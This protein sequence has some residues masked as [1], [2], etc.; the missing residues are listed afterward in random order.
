M[1]KFILLVCVLAAPWFAAG[2]QSPQDCSTAKTQ[3]EMNTCSGIDFQTAD[4]ELNKTYQAVLKK[5]ADDPAFITKLRA[6][7]LAWLKFREAELDAT[8]PH[9]GKASYYGTSYP[10][11]RAGKLTKLVTERTRQLREWLDGV[12]EGETCAGSVKRK[13]ALAEG[14]KPY[15]LTPDY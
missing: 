11:C 9:A 3:S 4:R 1:K 12:E 13:G 8:F 2:A 5:Y 14:M 6:S 15:F 10:L 7:Q